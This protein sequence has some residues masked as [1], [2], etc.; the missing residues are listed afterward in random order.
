MGPLFTSLLLAVGVA[1]WV[2]VK[3]QDKTGHGNSKN[4]VVG[5]GM[6]G[7]VLFIVMYLTLRLFWS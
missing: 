4:A 1:A 6:S 5:A 2:F 3:L 7:S